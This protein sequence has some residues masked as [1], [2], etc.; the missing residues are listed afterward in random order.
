MAGLLCACLMPHHKPRIIE[1]QDRLPNNH[2]AVL[3]FRSPLVGEVL[4]LPFKKVRVI[5]AALPWKNPV[6]DA[7]AYAYKCTGTYR[8]D[9]SMPQGVEE[10]ERWIAPPDLIRRMADRCDVL[11]SHP[12]DFSRTDSSKVISTV[13][14]SD[15]MQALN[16]PGRRPEFKSVTGVNMKAR[17]RGS[18]AYATLYVPSPKVPFSRITL[19]GEELIAEFPRLRIS[20]L[21]GEETML[22]ESASVLLGLSHVATEPRLI[23]QR[24]HKIEP[25]PDQERRAFIFWASTVQDRAFSL[26]RYACWRPGLLIDD[27]VKDIRL[28]DSWI[29]SE[30]PGYDQALHSTTWA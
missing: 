9:R 15:L 24:Y 2:S 25:I 16:Y 1:S 18:E 4:G 17:V 20:D 26:G 22:A 19:T 5:K 12:W 6:A 11:L 13:P 7:L 21:D 28:I 27:L 10:A 14:M 3:R 29:K 23:E 8:S 30:T